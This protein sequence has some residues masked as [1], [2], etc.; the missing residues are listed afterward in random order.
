MERRS[1]SSGMP[2]EP[3]VGYSRAVRVGDL[4]F[5]SGTT[6]TDA[7]G[8]VV[9][10]GDAYGQ[11]VR[12]HLCAVSAIEHDSIRAGGRFRDEEFI[13]LDVD[14]TGRVDVDAASRRIQDLC[15]DQGCQR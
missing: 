8:R 1:V 10:D 5:V 13:L 6:A 4:V 3:K 2:W 15:L 7:E 12:T 9:A 11:T 14:A